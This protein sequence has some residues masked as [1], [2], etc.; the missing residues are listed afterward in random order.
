VE[1][2]RLTESKAKNLQNEKVGSGFTFKRDFD[3][4]PVST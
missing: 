4:Y 3:N 2:N 1:N